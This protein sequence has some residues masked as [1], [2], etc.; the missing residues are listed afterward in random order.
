MHEDFFIRNKRCIL[1][2]AWLHNVYVVRIVARIVA[3]LESMICAHAIASP[4]KPATFE[5]L[6]ASRCLV[7]RPS[8]ALFAASIR[9]RFTTI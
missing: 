6:C 9:I 5:C 3:W 1:F 4:C 8:R 7:R 2:V